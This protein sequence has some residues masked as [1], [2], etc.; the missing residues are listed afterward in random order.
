MTKLIKIFDLRTGD[1]YILIQAALLMPLI[2]CSIRLFGLKKSRYWLG[3]LAQ[4]SNRDSTSYLDT[5]A[6]GQNIARL[7]AIASYK[8]LIRANCLQRSLCVWF[9]LLHRGID[10]DIRIGVRKAGQALAAHAWVEHIGIPLGES[11]IDLYSPFLTGG[12]GSS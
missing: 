10:S 11:N 8:G 6:L 7:V 9:L 5:L 1:V 12:M 2:S 3:Y 4:R